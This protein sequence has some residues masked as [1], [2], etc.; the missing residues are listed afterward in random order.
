MVNA[1]DESG[2]LSGW[3]G[4]I[5]SLSFSPFTTTSP[6]SSG[7]GAVQESPPFPRGR[8]WHLLAIIWLCDPSLTIGPGALRKEGAAAA[9][10]ALAD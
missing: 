10:L 9:S 2:E 1:S 7:G 4:A 8:H 5:N 6:P 3:T